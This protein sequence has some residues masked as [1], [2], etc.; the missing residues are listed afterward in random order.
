MMKDKLLIVIAITKIIIK[1]KTKKMIFNIVF[2]LILS[3]L[4]VNIYQCFFQ[5][6]RRGG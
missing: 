6:V 4:F 5:L 3:E 1:N 2:P